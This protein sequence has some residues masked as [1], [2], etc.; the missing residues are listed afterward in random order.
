MHGDKD[1]LVPVLQND[2][3]YEDLKAAGGVVDY[4]ILEGGGHGSPHFYQPEVKQIVL[5]FLNQYMPARQK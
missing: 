5:D 2:L 4:Y 3:F 1:A